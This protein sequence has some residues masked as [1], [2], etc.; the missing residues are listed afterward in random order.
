MKNRIALKLTLYF[1]AVLLVFAIII[2]GVFYQFFRQHTVDLKR[3]E[4][5]VRAERIA[6]VISDNMNFLEKRYGS[7]IANSRFISYLDNVSSEIV[8]W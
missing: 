2:G 8:W 3:Q 1:T 5:N 4:M 7:G 6:E